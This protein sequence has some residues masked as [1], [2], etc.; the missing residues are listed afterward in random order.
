MSMIALYLRSN[1][2]RIFALIAFA[3]LFLL[4][5]LTARL[6]VGTDHGQVE[7]GNLFMAGGYPL[8][9]ALLLLGWML[10]RYALVATLVMFAGIVSS[11]RANGNIRLYAVRPRW[12]GFLYL[13]KFFA[14]GAVVFVLSALLM[15]TFD[16]LLLG[17]WAG[18]GTFVLILSYIMVYG[19]VCFF[20][21]VWLRGEVWVTVVLAI[22]AMLWD[23]LI[24]S[25]K[26]GN[27]APGIREIVTV[28][29]PPQ[30]A[31]FQIES[32]FGAENPIPWASF[33]FVMAYAVILTVAALVSLRIREL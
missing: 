7:L 15:P 30:S 17:R 9:A 25:G 13:K 18:A 20:L 4:S 31:L 29:L 16:L 10:G 14:A 19:S 12:V 28:L 33:V 8:V 32:A 2:R 23:A 26:I 6:L 27:A 1:L 21:S 3:M 5:G 22:T 11:D 24:R